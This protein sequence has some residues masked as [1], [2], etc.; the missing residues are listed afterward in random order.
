[1][2]PVAQHNVR[3][4]LHFKH[5][6]FN[7]NAPHLY[8]FHGKFNVSNIFSVIFYWLHS[9]AWVSL[10]HWKWNS[11]VVT[12]MGQS[13][14]TFI[15]RGAVRTFIRLSWMRLMVIACRDSLPLAIIAI[16]NVCLKSTLTFKLVQF[17]STSKSKRFYL[18]Y[19]YRWIINFQFV[20][21]NKNVFIEI[22]SRNSLGYLTI[23]LSSGISSI[24][25]FII[26]IQFPLC[27][28]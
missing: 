10:Q 19:R 27:S 11:N 16:H 24:P 7:I 6:H 13:D 8:Y 2:F 14:I 12:W 26:L 5:Y 28:L 17:I 20:K 1:M 22:K 3:F 18:K 15:W 4:Y 25:G 21:S 23:K 9:T